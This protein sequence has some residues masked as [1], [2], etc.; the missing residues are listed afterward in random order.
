MYFF[1]KSLRRILFWVGAA[2]CIFVLIMLAAIIIPNLF[3]SES[4]G[5]KIGSIVSFFILFAPAY[6]A[7]RKLEPRYS[8][9]LIISARRREEFRER[10]KEEE[11]L[12]TQRQVEQNAKAQT[13]FKEQESQRNIKAQERAARLAVEKQSK[14]VAAAANEAFVKLAKQKIEAAITSPCLQ[15]S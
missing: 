10:D 12:A 1:F 14:Q 11:A 5:S 9:S 4:V 8:L 6:W 15:K 2:W 13:L 3:G 7:C